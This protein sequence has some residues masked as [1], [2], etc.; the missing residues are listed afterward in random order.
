MSDLVNWFGLHS[1]DSSDDDIP[2][3]TGVSDAAKVSA[4]ETGVVE[5]A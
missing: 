5:L 2:H 3:D 1:V 4:S